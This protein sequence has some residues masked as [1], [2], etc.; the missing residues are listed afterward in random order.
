MPEFR[1]ELQLVRGNMLETGRTAR[2][3]AA[4]SEHFAYLQDLTAKGRLV[5]VGRIMTTPENRMG[6]RC[7]RAQS[8]DK[9][10]QI[11]KGDPVV[12]KRV[13]TAGLDPSKV[14]LQQKQS[15]FN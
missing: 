9:A 6:W 3:Q 13:M 2:E 5:S 15:R 11:L 8:E 4:V 14:V 12:K 10:G 7:F 1:Y